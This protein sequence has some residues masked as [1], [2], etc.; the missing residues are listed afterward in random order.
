M[1]KL[2]PYNHIYENITIERISEFFGFHRSLVEKN[3]DGHDKEDDKASSRTVLREWLEEPNALY[4]IMDG[5]I[6]AGFMRINFRGPIAVWIEDIFVDSKFRGRG[7]ATA[8]INSLESIVKAD[9]PNCNAICM[10][11]AP[12]NEAAL[13]LYH[14]LG[15]RDLSLITLRKEIG[16]SKRDRDLELFGLDFKY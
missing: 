15:F 1:V 7:I 4:I 12:R 6:C 9:A 16:Q 14:R 2:I 13:K 3:D 11:V 8:A 10:D 5:E